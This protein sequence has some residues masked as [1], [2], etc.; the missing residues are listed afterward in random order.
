LIQVVVETQTVAEG[1][2][3]KPGAGQPAAAVQAVSEHSA[4]V[5][6]AHV[7]LVVPESSF[8]VVHSE[9][10]MGAPDK[11]VE[12]SVAELAASEQ[13]AAVH[14]DVELAAP[15][16]SAVVHSEVLMDAPEN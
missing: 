5:N 4:A 1:I 11:S 10:L 2:V 12:H 9:V 13:S 7:A 16:S 15:E 6:S 3:V 8:P 14:S